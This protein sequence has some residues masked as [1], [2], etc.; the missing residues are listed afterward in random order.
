MNAIQINLE[1]LTVLKKKKKNLLKSP[2]A[3]EESE[4]STF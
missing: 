1:N 2:T 3:K 4:F